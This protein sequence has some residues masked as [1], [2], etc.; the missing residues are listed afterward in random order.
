MSD[1]ATFSGYSVYPSW[2]NKRDE[3]YALDG[4]GALIM[5]PLAVAQLEY[6][7]PIERLPVAIGILR[8]RACDR[9]DAAIRTLST[10]PTPER[11]NT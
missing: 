7:N 3:L 1:R 10:T 8:D 2:R 4:G 11:S 9:L 6:P 5:H